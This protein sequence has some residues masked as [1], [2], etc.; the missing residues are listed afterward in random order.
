MNQ[1]MTKKAIVVEDQPIIWEYAKSCIEPHFEVLEFCSSTEEAELAFRKHKPDLVWL[2]CYL[3]EVSETHFGVKNS[4]IELAA[5]IKSH[6]PETKV[7]L[8]TASNEMSI[9]EFA[10]K[11]EIEGIALG[12]KYLKDKSIVQ[13]GIK[14]LAEGNSWTSPN[15]IDHWELKSLGKITL[16]EFCIAS[17]L[18]IGK[19]ASQIAD[20][21]DTT[22]KRV[23]SA[24][25]RIREKLK[26]E[27][28]IGRDEFLEILKDKIKSCFSPNQYYNLTELTTI[29]AMVESCLK[30]LI[31]ELKTGDL[32]RVA[33]EETAKQ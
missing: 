12:G 22:R 3:G 29:N 8:F 9:F 32:K 6:S 27:D 18:I 7:F 11:H 24:I 19:S 28:A 17:L 23:N 21:L 5:W 16:F 20:E 4:G 1:E 15:I 26:I 13:E 25:Y 31:D 30:P 10:R 2:D 14:A 33:I